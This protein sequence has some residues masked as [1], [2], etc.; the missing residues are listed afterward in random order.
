MTPIDQAVRLRC[1]DG[2][3]RVRASTQELDVDAAAR[4]RRGL[5]APWLP[6]DRRAQGETPWR[7]Q[8]P[9]C[10]RGS[11]GGA[12]PARQGRGALV[13][14]T[15]VGNSPDVGLA[16]LGSVEDELGEITSRLTNSSGAQAYAVTQELFETAFRATGPD[17]WR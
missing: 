4:S 15:L 7:Q 10:L 16:I 9:S 14:V 5:S 8:H 2:V 12:L 13:A 3:P 17:Y 1:I 11:S 6:N